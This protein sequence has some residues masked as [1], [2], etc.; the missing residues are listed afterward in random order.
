[1]GICTGTAGKEL[2]EG[3]RGVCS[4]K[5]GSTRQEGRLQMKFLGDQ[6]RDWI[7]FILLLMSLAYKGREC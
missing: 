7:C 2:P 3:E 5:R 1:M 6:S 4:V